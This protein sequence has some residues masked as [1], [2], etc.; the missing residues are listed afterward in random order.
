MNSPPLS[1]CTSRRRPGRPREAA[2][3]PPPTRLT[4]S[5]HT[6][7]TS[8]QPVAT[9]TNVSVVRK[10]PSRLSPQCRTRSACTEPGWTSFHSLQVRIGICAF[11][12]VV[13]AAGRRGCRPRFLRQLP[14]W[15][16]VVAALIH[17]SPSR[18]PPPAPPP[19]P[20]PPP[21]DTEAAA[22]SHTR[23]TSAESRHPLSVTLLLRQRFPFGN[24]LSE[25][26]RGLAPIDASAA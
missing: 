11:R 14:S 10:K 22:W 7:S 8:V 6:A 15:R 17:I 12:P 1:G 9:S 18:N 3:P 25:A 23:T 20:P 19:P 4:P 5:P 26:D 21:A 16:S 2:S 13:A 24:R